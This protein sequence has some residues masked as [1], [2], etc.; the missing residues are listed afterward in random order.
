MKL[1]LWDKEFYLAS[2]ISSYIASASAPANIM[3]LN[4]QT[5]WLITL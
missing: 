5:L 3:A 2:E 4:E 1:A